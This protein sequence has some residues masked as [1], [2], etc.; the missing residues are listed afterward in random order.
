MRDA[1][2]PP[3]HPGHDG[4][5]ALPRADRTQGIR[6]AAAE[7]LR[8]V[9]EW[10]DSPNW[11]G[12]PAEIRRYQ[13]TVDAFS[14]LP[15]SETPEAVVRLVETAHRV[16]AEWRS[17]R[18]GSAQAVYAAVQRLQQATVEHT[19]LAEKANK[20]PGMQGGWN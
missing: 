6:T 14:T 17:A 10:H 7:V 3:D 12:K 1:D 20:L 2:L 9:Q 15:A 5:G 19:T 18:P 11:R 4:D 13:V 16:I 8:H